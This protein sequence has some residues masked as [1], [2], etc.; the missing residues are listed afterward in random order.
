MGRFF[1]ATVR[2][3][4]KP[5]ATI[6]SDDFG[7]SA[8]DDTTVFDLSGYRSSAEVRDSINE[9]TKNGLLNLR[10]PNGLFITKKPIL[11]DENAKHK[12]LIEIQ[13]QQRSADTPKL[14]RFEIKNS[15]KSITK[16][17]SHVNLVLI[18]PD[19]KIDEFLDSEVLSLYT[20][21]QAFRA[22]IDNFN[23]RT[24]AAGTDDND[25][26]LLTGT[27]DENLEGLPD[28]PRLMQDWIPTE[29]TKTKE[30]LKE[31]I[32]RVSQPTRIGSLNR[33]YYWEITPVPNTYSADGTSI[34]D[35][36][37][38]KYNITGGLFGAQPA[39]P[40]IISTNEPITRNVVQESSALLDNSRFKDI[41]IGKG[42][43]GAHSIPMAHAKYV[44]DSTHATQAGFY[45]TNAEYLTGDYVK[46]NNK[47][48]KLTG[49]DIDDAPA[50]DATTDLG[51]AW[52]N[53]IDEY[54][55]PWMGTAIWRSNLSG[56]GQLGGYYAGCFHDF[57]IVRRDFSEADEFASVS[58][59]DVINVLNT[60]PTAPQHGQRWLIGTSPTGSWATRQNTI[61]QWNDA[62]NSWGYSKYPDGDELIHVLHDATMRHW[63]GSAWEIIW[64]V[65]NTAV[66]PE[67]PSPFIPVESIS[68]DSNRLGV[69]GK[70]IKFTFDWNIFS[71]VDEIKD[72]VSSGLQY[73]SKYLGSFGDIIAD[74]SDNIL[75]FIGKNIRQ[76]E[77]Y[78]TYVNNFYSND[79]DTDDAPSDDELMD[80]FGTA[81]SSAL[82]LR[83]RASRRFGW[84]IKLPW[85]QDAIQGLTDSEG[86]PLSTLDFGNMSHVYKFR[87]VKGWNRG[88]LSENLGAIRGVEFWQ[89][90]QHVNGGN[91]N[92][93]GISNI[94]MLFW[95]RDLFDRV[96]Y[97]PYT[98]RV[99]ND[100]AKY[101]IPAGIGSSLTQYDSRVDELATLF[102]YT[103]P[104]D[105]FIKERELTGGTFDWTHA[106]EMGTF[107]TTSYSDNYVYTGG[108]DA[109]LNL[110][111]DNLARATFRNPLLYETANFLG[112]MDVEYFITDKVHL[113]LEDL[114]FV[115]DAYVTSTND[116][117]NAPGDNPRE[118]LVHLPSQ[119][120][121]V[122]IKGILDRQRSRMKF[123]PE[124]HILSTSGNINLKGGEGFL[125]GNYIENR[126]ESNEDTTNAELAAQQVDHI[127]KGNGYTCAV[128]G[129]R[130]YQT[131]DDIV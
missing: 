4:A 54:T 93:T 1:T 87:N 125:L 33:D 58:V 22:R 82:A 75:T 39:T 86:L 34:T 94:P 89:K 97:H 105:H 74:T 72:A 85:S 113:Y 15:T 122:N 70:A 50:V 17:G 40:E 42:A 7:G 121:Y 112:I 65:G 102:G 127:L 57:N 21:R 20:P 56:S 80:E 117:A 23:N 129:I 78:S 110:F 131:G 60:P 28:D 53:I 29:P 30:H 52:S 26:V 61:A 18:A 11:V 73:W 103:L 111:A 27:N 67:R 69:A 12:F 35:D 43:K 31:I 92:L 71:D 25:V 95:F 109:F 120:D 128:T 64:S 114:H 3:L 2:L 37:R 124:Q 96:V 47:L 46:H 77:D 14:F 90:A 123:H 83:N 119:H 16:H 10:A 55:N 98:M 84:S 108:Q 6:D 118:A 88:T 115:K 49:S 68:L 99:H 81:L 19:A 36:N 44:S 24:Q 8:D 13:I 5:D 104:F 38:Q 101:R 66:N 126:G 79:I 59:K 63:T 41:L 32:S 116:T 76:Q 106:V 130:K 91:H 100:W 51:T 107:S 45:T 9:V 62:L 48:W